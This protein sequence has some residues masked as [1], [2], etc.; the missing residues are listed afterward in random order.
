MSDKDELTAIAL[1]EMAACR[2]ALHALGAAKGFHSGEYRESTHAIK[3][4]ETIG[5]LLTGDPD[6]FRDPHHS[7]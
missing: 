7:T 3:L 4:I 5:E 2:K 6:Y 1:T